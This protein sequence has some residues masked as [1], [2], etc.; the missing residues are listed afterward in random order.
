M[1]MQVML[2]LAWMVGCADG[3]PVVDTEVPAPAP[4]DCDD[5]DSDGVCD[6]VDVCEGD[7]ATGDVDND[8]ICDDRDACTGDD[9]VGDFDLD[10][11]CDDLDLCEGDDAT[12]DADGDGQCDDVDP[13]F[14]DNATGDADGDGRCADVDTCEDRFN[15][16][17]EPICNVWFVSETATG[18]GDGTSWADAFVH[19]ADALAI[20]QPGEAIWVAQ[21]RYA[22]AAER[23]TF[24]LQ[25]VEGVAVF[26]GF[27]GTELDLADRAG[28]FEQTVITGDFLGDDD[29]ANPDGTMTDN[30][31]HLVRS[32]VDA[33]LDGFWLE[34]AYAASDE[35]SGVGV[36]HNA[37]GAFTLRNV[38]LSNVRTNGSRGILF[39]NSRNPGTLL[40]DVA[41]FDSTGTV[42][43]GFSGEMDIVGFTIRNVDVGVANFGSGTIVGSHW[44]V[45]TNGRA[46]GNS[47]GSVTLSNAA[48]WTDEG[49]TVVSNGGS[50]TITDACANQDLEN[51][52]SPTIHLDE[53][54][55][56]LGFPF[57]E[58]GPRL[59]LAQNIIESFT[60]ACVDAG[61]VAV[62]SQPNQRSTASDGTIDA[63]EVD[64]GAA[65]LIP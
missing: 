8:G 20:A 63:N 59:F 27:D 28:A 54:T 4:V 64:A 21:G 52:G 6:E 60:S 19:P 5:A 14:G 30:V 62:H 55:D 42:V 13:C 31:E 1:R 58:D 44:S 11:T 49:S 16:N 39:L 32:E 7:D 22:P 46:L 50:V 24:A 57:V 10:G 53:S 17:D 18:A 65:Y 25:L 40:E 12:G 3:E 43:V 29:L 9:A 45:H 35:Q 41:V 47:G 36:Q 51:F 48:L 37:R 56:E 26:G 15:P 61:G 2:G 33:V 34:G 23:Q 38:T